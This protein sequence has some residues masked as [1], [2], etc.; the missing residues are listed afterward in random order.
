MEFKTQ[1][2]KLEGAQN[3]TKWKRQVGLL[4]RHHEVLDIVEGRSVKP[5]PVA[6]DATAE[7]KA[8][9]ERDLKTFM[10][11]DTKAQ[12]ILVNSLNDANVELT[13]TCDSAKAVWDKLVSIF[14]QSS[15]Q[16]L[17]RLLEQF[18][19]VTKDPTENIATHVAKLQRLFSDVNNELD[20]LTQVKM[21][22]LVLMSRVMHTLPS[23]YFEFKSVWESVKMEERTIDKLTERLRLIEMRLPGKGGDESTA[24]VAAKSKAKGNAKKGSSNVKCF[25]CHGTGHIA[26]D[27]PK[28]NSSKKE[29][30]SGETLDVRKERK[31]PDGEAFVCDT[32]GVHASDVWIADTGCTAHM[33]N[34]RNYF[35]FYEQFVKPMEIR[36]GNKEIILAHG[37]GTVNVEMLIG[38][39][40]QRNH[41]HNVWFVPDV[42]RNLFSVGSMPKDMNF[43]TDSTGCRVVKDGKTRIKGKRTENGLYALLMRVRIPEQPANVCAVAAAV[44]D[45]QLWHERLGHQNKRRVKK[46]LKRQGIDVVVNEQFCEGC[47][48]GKQHRESFGTR[49]NRPNEVGWLINADLCGPMQE[50]SVGG[51]KYFLC[52]KDDYSGYR[53]VF[54]LKQK[55][56]VA[57]KLKVYLA[58]VD[59][60][61]HRMRELLTDGGKEFDNAEVREVLASKGINFRT[62]MPYT[63]EQNGAAERENRTLVESARSMVHAKHLPVKLWAEAVNTAAYILNRTGPTAVIDKT[64]FELWFGEIVKS[65]DHL[66]V[67]GTECYVHVPKQKR[68]K[69]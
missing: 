25:R 18:F 28:K 10:Q 13:S 49:T 26:K 33:T 44:D 23:E 29:A 19:S 52:F 40:W 14:D 69:L 46:F 68:R 34:Q 61:G 45:I 31:N 63:P 56:E 42:G 58:E 15:G 47:V 67:F 3:W 27:C 66:K 53:R 2:D 51:A 43:V 8:N 9:Y 21:P 24:F 35:L 57:E 38:G 22:D 65:M 41:L 37:Q 62:T 17:D 11:G 30:S 59:A 5:A 4:L 36:V 55:S 7:V 6:A 50:E 60:A 48:Y 12:L 20:R 54:F 16:R 1:I 39:E 64:P 32:L